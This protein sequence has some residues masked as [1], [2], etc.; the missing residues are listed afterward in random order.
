MKCPKCAYVGFDATDRCRHCGY[1]FSLVMTAPVGAATPSTEATVD[2]PLSLPPSPSPALDLPLRTLESRVPAL[3]AEPAPPPAGTPLAVRRTADRPRSRPVPRLVRSRPM[4]AE[5]DAVERED[6]VPREVIEAPAAWAPRL[7]AAAIDL[8]L[9]AAID[10]AAVYLTTRIAG[11]GVADVTALPLVPLGVFLFGIDAAY[12]FVFTFQGG[13]TLGKMALGLRVEGVDGPL[14]AG[15]ALLRVLAA[16]AGSAALG[17]GFVVAGW[18]HDRRTF[19][20]QVAG[21]RVVKVT[22]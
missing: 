8:V 11:L 3:F 18:R 16:L 5:L 6:E 2:P 15:R 13:Q 14:T 7:A 19:H 12:L 4:L 22:A 17:L 9:L 21:T 20:D 10:G 1:D